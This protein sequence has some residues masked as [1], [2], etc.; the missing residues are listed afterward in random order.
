[1]EINNLILRDWKEND[2]P[3]LYEMCLDSALRK[4]G[5]ASFP[6]VEDSLSAIKSWMNNPGSKVIAGRESH[7]FAGFISLGDM[8]RYDAYMELEYAVAAKYRNRGYAAQ[9]VKRM[10]AYGFTQLNASVIAAWVRSH[11]QASVRVLEKCSFTFEG[12]LR[13]HARDQSDTLCYSLLREEWER[14]GLPRPGATA[15]DTKER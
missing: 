2:A 11:N 9:A 6:S 1:M 15:A 3:D 4:S 5:I 7:H 10:A 13:K 14:Q 8:N 12:R